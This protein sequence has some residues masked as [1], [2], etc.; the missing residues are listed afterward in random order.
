MKSQ[1][2]RRVLVVIVNYR[3]AQLTLECLRSLEPERALPDLDIR[4]VVVENDSGDGAV[5]ER[6]LAQFQGVT[7][8]QA[9]RNGGFSYGNNLGF[10]F[11]YESGWIPD[12]FHLLN[13]DTRISPGAIQSLVRFMDGHPRAAIAGSRF[14]NG[15]GSEWPYAFRFPSL[16]SEVEAALRVGMATRLLENWMILKPMGDGPS[17][18]DWIPGAS[19]LVRRELIEQIGGLDEEYFLYYEETDFCLKARR[20]GWEC[21]HVPESRVMHL[22]GASTGVSSH[23]AERPMPGYWFESR[24]RY[25]KRNHGYLYSALTNGATIAAQ[26][27]G[28]A[29]QRALR[30]GSIR[31]GFVKGLLKRSTLDLLSR[32]VAPE[33][34]FKPESAEAHGPTDRPSAD[35]AA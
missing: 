34:A 31:P 33:R 28:D 13:P 12:Y 27:L 1:R 25:F 20:H 26:L 30:R 6:D 22:A 19:M 3:S 8:I 9:A 7:L 18:V 21:W 11:A 10:R 24:S 16:L 23:E 32:H 5:L 4:V 15:D 14:Q 2:K 29:K 17:Q 35:A